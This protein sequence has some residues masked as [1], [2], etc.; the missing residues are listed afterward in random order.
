[1]R[2]GPSVLG[3]DH[4]PDPTRPGDAADQ[5]AEVRPVLQGREDLAQ[6]VALGELG[7]LHDVEQPVGEDLLDRGRVVIAQDP[8]D[9]IPDALGDALH[10]VGTIEAGQRGLGG[11]SRRLEQVLVEHRRD[12]VEGG[13]I[14]RVRLV[15][16]D[17][18]LL[19]GTL[20]EDQ[21]EAGHPFVDR[22]EV[23]PADVGDR[24]LGR[25]RQTRRPGEAGQGRRREAEPVLAREFDLTELV[26]DHQL[27]DRRQGRGIDDRFDVEPIPGVGRHAPGA[28]MRMAQQP[29]HLQLSQDVADG[30]AGHAEGVALDE[31]QTAD[32]LGGGDVFLDDGPKDRLR[33][34]V[35]RAERA[36][37]PSRQT[38][39]PVVVSTRW[40]RVLTGREAS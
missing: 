30:R 23:D 26:A 22:D 8:D 15:E 32:R 40:V 25:R 27:L 5:L 12:P 7:R 16:G 19:D 9:P 13:L 20:P 2:V 31:C 6:L 18:R 1:M 36:A 39:S 37:D 11:G 34:E 17:R 29:S 3:A 24:G 33:A 4:D 14:D 21:D 35:Q 28:G 10:G 38:R